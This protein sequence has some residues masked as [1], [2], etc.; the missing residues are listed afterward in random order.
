MTWILC[1]HLFLK[2]GAE[3]AS[4]FRRPVEGFRCSFLN[5]DFV[6]P[7]TVSGYLTIYAYIYFDAGGFW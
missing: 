6:L 4:P 2:A 5:A 1:F 7:R 3:R